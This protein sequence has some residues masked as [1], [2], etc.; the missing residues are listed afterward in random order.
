MLG[1]RD[2]QAGGGIRTLMGFLLFLCF[3]FLIWF[4]PCETLLRKSQDILLPFLLFLFSGL[5]KNVLVSSS[6]LYM[7][8]LL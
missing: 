2:G 1:I 4:P 8:L 3:Q 7:F 5:L 6:F